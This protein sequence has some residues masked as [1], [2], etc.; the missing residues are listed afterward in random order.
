MLVASAK[1]L[2]EKHKPLTKKACRCYNQK[3]LGN[4]GC[5]H[6]RPGR[7]IRQEEGIMKKGITL[8][9]GFVFLYVTGIVFA[10]DPVEGYWLSVD[11]KTNRVTAGWYIYQ[12]G[13]KLYGKILSLADVRRDALAEDC[14][15][16]YPGFPT[17][18]RVSRM[19]VVGTIWIY[20]LSRVKTGEWSG[21]T[22]IDPA[23]GSAYDCKIVFHPADG[24]DYRIDTLQ[25][26][27]SGFLGI[28][29]SQY[30]RKTDEQTA[31]SLRPNK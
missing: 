20:G 10:A 9:F 30:W 25:M 16:S 19:T 5:T 7:I 28:G 23:S 17:P 14:K 8:A 27:G 24:K 4:F 13:G 18:G 21:G 22:V 31:S 29:R 6:E 11:E 26:R 15:D 1:S 2:T 3:G 12:Q